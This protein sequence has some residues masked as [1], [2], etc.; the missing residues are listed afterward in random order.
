VLSV[1]RLLLDP[2]LM[3]AAR[4]AGAEVLMGAK[5]TALVR[6]RG[7]VTGVRVA[8]NGP[9]QTLEAGLVVG[10]DGRNSTIARLAGS[11]QYNLTANER[12]MY[13]SFFA[14]ADPGAGPSVILHRWSG[15]LVVAI[16]ADSGL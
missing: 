9:A 12:F 6:D 14:G 5:V 10:A 8:R 15:N 3:E 11:R 13:W 7:R 1:R 4:D 2:I 16:P